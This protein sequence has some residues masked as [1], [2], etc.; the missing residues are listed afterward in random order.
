MLARDRRRL[1]ATNF[2][3]HRGGLLDWNRANDRSRPTLFRRKRHPGIDFMAG[4]RIVRPWAYPFA[5]VATPFAVAL[6]FSRL[7]I[8]RACAFAHARGRGAGL[9]SLLITAPAFVSM[10]AVTVAFQR[11]RE[12]GLRQDRANPR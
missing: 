5:I 8:P 4:D 2:T 9:K 3:N 12:D 10:V 11:P 7:H 1:I 6:A